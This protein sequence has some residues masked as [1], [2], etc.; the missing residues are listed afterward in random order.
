[1]RRIVFTNP[2]VIALVSIFIGYFFVCVGCSPGHGYISIDSGSEVMRPIF[3]LYGDPYFQGR[4]DIGTVIVR[5]AERSSE[6]KKGSELDTPHSTWKTVWELEYK[7]S[8]KWSTSTVACLTYGEVPPGYREKV[9]AVPL[10]PEELYSVRIEE[11][12]SAKYPGA[13]KFIIRLD[14]EGSPDRL[15]YLSEEY[16]VFS[17][18]PFYLRLY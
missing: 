17:S 3:C 18:A 8:N 14:G 6:M 5:K 15:E 9:K 16:D 1:M 4:L 10:E 13:L 2:T 11:H 7:P 12:N